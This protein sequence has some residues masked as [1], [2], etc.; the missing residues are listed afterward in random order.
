MFTPIWLELLHTRGCWQWLEQWLEQPL[1]K[2][3]D[4]QVPILSGVNL[5]DLVFQSL[6]RIAIWRGAIVLHLLPIQAAIGSH[7]RL[8]ATETTV[9]HPTVHDGSSF[10]T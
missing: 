10:P 5:F 4:Y 8:S 6:E 1:T 9:S 3:F 2:A 7:V